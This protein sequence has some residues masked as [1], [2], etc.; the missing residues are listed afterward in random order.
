RKSGTRNEKQYKK[1]LE[2]ETAPF[3]GI[4]NKET[5]QEKGIFQ[6]LKKKVISVKAW[7][8]EWRSHVRAWRKISKAINAI[9]NWLWLLEDLAIEKLKSNQL[10]VKK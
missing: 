9:S 7:L 4:R 6:V 2:Q 10:I 5:E 1:V 3:S 8:A